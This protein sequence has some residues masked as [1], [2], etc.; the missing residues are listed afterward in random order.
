VCLLQVRRQHPLQVIA[1]FNLLVFAGLLDPQQTNQWNKP[2]ELHSACTALEEEKQKSISSSSR[3]LRF[4]N[5][6]VSVPNENIS[7][8]GQQ[9]QLS[10]TM[11]IN[12]NSWNCNN[13]CCCY[14]NNNNNNYCYFSYKNSCVH[15]L[16]LLQLNVITIT[17][18][19]TKN[20][21]S[22]KKVPN[23]CTCI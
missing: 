13:C 12:F 15:K 20:S 19:S 8:D 11:C 16:G 1:S 14:K 5:W 9:K 7:R 3:D 23:L 17:L 4:F 22:G 2:T 21:R 6:F 18:V 10:A